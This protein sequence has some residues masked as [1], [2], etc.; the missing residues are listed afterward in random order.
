MVKLALESLRQEPEF[1]VH[2]V[3][4]RFSFTLDEIGGGS[5]RKGLLIFKYLAEALWRRLLVEN[6]LL[7]Y[8][9]GP[10]KWS[11]VLRDWLVLGILRLFYTRV[12]FHWHAIGHGEW[13]HGSTRGSLKLS[14]PA[15]LDQLARKMSRIILEAPEASFAV[16]A[17]STKDAEAVGSKKL[18]VVENG[19]LDPCAS[20]TSRIAVENG[21]SKRLRI[22]FLSHGTVQ[23]GLLD[24]TKALIGL[25]GQ[26]E[27]LPLEVTFAGGISEP[28]QEE[29]RRDVAEIERKSGG[30]IKVRSLGYLSADEMKEQY[31]SHDIF[32]GASRWES[33][34]LTVVEAMAHR[35]T[36]VAAASD[37]VV[38]VL[39][40]GYPYL[41]AVAD[42]HDLCEKLVRCC[43]D[44]RN[45]LCD[46]LGEE[47]RHRFLS[48]FQLDHFRSALLTAFGE[49]AA[50]GEH[51]ERV[52]AAS[53]DADPSPVSVQIYLADQHPGGDRSYGISRMSQMAIS[54]FHIHGGFEMT[55]VV[56]GSSQQSPEG[57]HEVKRLPWNTRRKW[58]RLLTDHAHPLLPELQG[59]MDV[60]YYPKGYLPGISGILRPSVVTIHDTIVQYDADH[61]PEWRS[62][63]EYRYWAK[64]LCHTLKK[65][66]RILTV[67]QSSKAQIQ[68]F[69]QRYGLP[70][71][72]IEVTYEP[73]SFEG[74]PQPESKETG[75]YVIHLASVEPHKRTAHLIRWW[76]EAELAGRNLP[77]LHLIGSVPEEVMPLVQT[78]GKIIKRPFLDT[79]ELIRAYRDAQALILPSEIE[80]FGLPAL[81]AYYLGTPVCFVRGTSVEEVLSPVTGKGGFDLGELGSLFDA[82]EEVRRMHQA[83]VRECGLRLREIYSSGKFAEVMHCI[84]SEVKRSA[85]S[86]PTQSCLH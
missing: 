5:L 22:L 49:M 14:G 31:R 38:G 2:H 79:A 52:S 34:G 83:E 41:A 48:H 28:V 71:R 46:G 70:E 75:D 33:F 61:Y 59:R 63:Y 82:L 16:S 32:L 44:F 3:N 36:I 47:L 24:A 12:I 55:V 25:A 50:N 18:W 17:N 26:A 4:A 30:R 42:P 39:P 72:E 67:S 56:S 7:Y 29:F 27:D 76:R 10:V 78:S 53:P 57:V 13:A 64:M 40:P 80:G 66:D 54:A 84:F 45:G 19:L 85:P 77:T 74:I 6:P 9:P 21:A 51:V 86:T 8:V 15:W 81:E 58:V 37:G 23:K 65:A 60:Y 1:S 62:S 35:M 68:Q 73:C 11:A 69:I 43:S 20:A